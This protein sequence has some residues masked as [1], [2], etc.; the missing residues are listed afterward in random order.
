MAVNY[1]PTYKTYEDA[2]AE[3]RR[4]QALAEALQQQAYQPIEMT[5][6]APVSYTQGL[7]KVLQAYMAGRQQSKAAEAE[8]QAKKVGREEFQSYL[9]SLSPEQKT[10]GVGDIAAMQMPTPSIEDGRITHQAAAPILNQKPVMQMTAEG[11]PDFSKPMMM[12]TGGPL[13]PG[14]RRAKL[15]EGLGSGNPMVQTIAQMEL[16]RKP[17]EFDIKETSQGL[18]RVGKTTGAVS[19]LLGPNGM[20]LTPRDAYSMGMTPDQKA[21][22]D[23]DVRKYGVEVA[24]ARL[25]QRQAA[26]KGVDVSGL[27]LPSAPP[28][29]GIAPPPAGATPPTAPVRPPR[30][31]QTAA[32]GQP[33]APQANV[34]LIESNRISNEQKREYAA[35]QPQVK[36][37]TINMLSEASGIDSMAN[38]L[39]E[40]GGLDK[41]TGPFGQ[42][43]TTDM[44]PEARSARAIYESMKGRMALLRVAMARAESSTGGAYGNLTENEWP[45]LEQ[46]LGAIG[47]AQ[48]GDS[49]KNALNNFRS[50]LGAITDNTKGIYTD[51]YGK[52]DFTPPKYSP[53]SKRF[54]RQTQQS[55]GRSD[56]RRQADDI[57]GRD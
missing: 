51:T 24:N 33:P 23:L 37:A 34:P 46:S 1:V 14:Q 20:P 4:A 55:Q 13:T 17:E 26:D 8:R 52:L 39:L 22:Y 48:D 50:A 10:M 12:Q 25:S 2:S 9:E 45:R 5:A 53:E 35:K 3:A 19:P 41:I 44:A 7:A 57:L 54:P 6:A 15:L 30:P 29:A 18:V 49:L 38:D 32:P 42:I 40:H 21:R 36:G 28:T 43:K 31:G 27:G 47:L 11:A 16:S 56:V